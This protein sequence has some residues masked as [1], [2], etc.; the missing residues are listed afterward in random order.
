M[1][2]RYGIWITARRFIAVGIDASDEAQAP[3]L[4]A[5]TETA[6]RAMLDE[7]ARRLPVELVVSEEILDEAP[8]PLAEIALARG[9]T[10]W[11][12]PHALVRGVMQAA[13]QRPGPRS[14]RR[15][16]ETAARLPHIEAFQNFMRLARPHD[17][18]H[19]FGF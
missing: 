14:A 17:P 5:R 11:I 10:V 16:A 4:A 19:L 12:A 7:L 2:L 1:S 18:Q 13:G 15:A 9:I 8:F 6:Y 3:L